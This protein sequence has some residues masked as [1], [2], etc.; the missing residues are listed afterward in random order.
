[1]PGTSPAS[2]LSSFEGAQKTSADA[3]KARQAHNLGKRQPTASTIR[4]GG[5]RATGLNFESDFLESTT[6][7]I[8]PELPP[9][10]KAP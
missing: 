4:C 8:P 1:M 9:L 10:I 3:V 7:A 6:A 5:Q 2:V